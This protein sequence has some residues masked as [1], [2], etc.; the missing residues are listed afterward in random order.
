MTFGKFCTV[1]GVLGAAAG[2][3]LFGVMYTFRDSFVAADEVRGLIG[4]PTMTIDGRAGMILAVPALTIGLALP[5]LARKWSD[6]WGWV[7]VL[8]LAFFVMAA[9]LTT[10]ALQAG[11]LPGAGGILDGVPVQLGV[12]IATTA[13]LRGWLEVGNSAP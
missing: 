13:L 4:H 8:P 3:G 12:V 5:W 1:S 11:Y 9:V 6:R 7:L 10:A 2:A